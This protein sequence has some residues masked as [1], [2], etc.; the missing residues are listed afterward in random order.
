MAASRVGINFVVANNAMDAKAWHLFAVYF[1][2]VGWGRVVALLWFERL[3]EIDMGSRQSRNAGA[4]LDGEADGKG[5][6]GWNP[7]A[8][9]EEVLARTVAQPGLRE[10]LTALTDQPDAVPAVLSV[11]EVAR[12]A[13]AAADQAKHG[14]IFDALHAVVVDRG[15]DIVRTLTECT[16]QAKIDEIERETPAKK[17]R[18]APSDDR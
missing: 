15:P 6:G 7:R 12:L 13:R 14:Q 5:N 4:R 2:V 11:V 1:F 8:E 10:A 17:N 9:L 3:K 18:K 16:A